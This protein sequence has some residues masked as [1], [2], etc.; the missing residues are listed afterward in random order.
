MASRGLLSSEIIN[1]DLWWKGPKWLMQREYNT[2]EMKFETEVEQKANKTI[3]LHTTT[4]NIDDMS[5]RFSSLGRAI[6]VIALC[7]RFYKKM[8][9]A[10]HNVNKTKMKPMAEKYTLTQAQ[11]LEMLSA[12]SYEV[13]ELNAAKIILIKNCQQSHFENEIYALNEKIELSKSNSLRPLFPFIDGNRLLR[14]GGRLQKS[15]F[16]YNKKHPLIIPYH[17]NL[18][19]LIVK[20][21]HQKLMH[22]GNH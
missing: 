2:N 20:D 9:N 1:N 21:A 13:D 11:L 10:V 12:V 5:A 17:S 16:T 3:L 19:T 6:R 7:I 14:V 18:A 4:N 22:A 8:K 15:N